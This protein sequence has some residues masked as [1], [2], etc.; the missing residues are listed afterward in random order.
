[1]TTIFER[2]REDHDKHR[3]LLGLVEK[4]E[5]DSE[6][7]RELFERLRNDMTAHANAEE[8]CF[9]ARLLE[10]DLTQE[11]GRH[12]VSE[13]HDLDCLLKELCELEYSSPQWLPKFRKLKKTAEHHM[14]EEEHIVFQMAGKVLTESEKRDLVRV[15]NTLK[16]EEMA[17]VK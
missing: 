16:D 1:M 10:K 3:T 4:T 7:R 12:S 11:K 17:A 14:E 5:G 9:Y 2:I 15:F 6:G 13:H 8:R